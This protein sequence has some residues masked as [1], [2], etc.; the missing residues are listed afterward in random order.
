MGCLWC[1]SYTPGIGEGTEVFVLS[2][3]CILT[4]D[5]EAY[6]VHMTMPELFE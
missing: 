5:V 3:D 4:L 6:I 2:I 1:F